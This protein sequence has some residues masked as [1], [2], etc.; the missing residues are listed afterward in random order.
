[1]YITL[2]GMVFTGSERIPRFTRSITGF[3]EE[4]QP[5]PI[6][7]LMIP[8][9]YDV[10]NAYLIPSTANVRVIGVPPPLTLAPRPPES[11]VTV[12]NNCGQP[13]KLSGGH[14]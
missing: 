11:G 10:P 7:V 9:S 12:I 14:A 8:E 5:S 13:A 6:F 2:H 4:R 1:M 3:V